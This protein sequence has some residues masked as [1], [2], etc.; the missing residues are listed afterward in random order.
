MSASPGS[1]A[2]VWA[3]LVASS[4]KKSDGK[5]LKSGSDRCQKR[6]HTARESYGHLETQERLWKRGL[7]NQN[8]RE[9]K[10]SLE[11]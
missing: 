2:G 7:G 4:I 5:K 9:Q 6:E 1:D 11:N 3:G 10:V 8:W